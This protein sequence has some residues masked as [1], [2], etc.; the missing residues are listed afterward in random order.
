M[1]KELITPEEIKRALK[2]VDLM[3]ILDGQV[4]VGN[5]SNS[6]AL[7]EHKV[8]CPVITLNQ[9]TI[10]SFGRPSP[11]PSFLPPP[12]PPLRRLRP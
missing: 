5:K 3:K 6:K 9:L 11:F 2:A 4:S 8:S 1:N 7:G 12:R 10:V